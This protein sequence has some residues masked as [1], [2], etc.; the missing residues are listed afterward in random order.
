MALHLRNS[1]YDRYL[2][3]S[4][5]PPTY[6][7]QTLLN[8]AAAIHAHF[9]AN[10]PA[11][12][13]PPN[14]PAARNTLS[15]AVWTD[16][17]IRTLQI[18][19]QHARVYFELFALSVGPDRCSTSLSSTG[20]STVDDSWLDTAHIPSSYLLLLLHNQL[21][22]DVATTSHSNDDVN[23]SKTRYPQRNLKGRCALAGYWRNTSEEWLRLIHILK[24]G[25]TRKPDR[26]TAS[27]TSDFADV[28]NFLYTAV[29]YQDRE[30][31]ALFRDEFRSWVR[32]GCGDGGS[33][34]D[35]QGLKGGGVPVI[36][37]DL[38]VDVYGEED[39]TLHV[40][41]AWVNWM[42]RAR[43]L[44]FDKLQCTK[45]GVIHGIRHV[46]SVDFTEVDEINVLLANKHTRT[47]LIPPSSSSQLLHLHIH[48]CTTPTIH[49]LTPLSSLTISDCT[50]TTIT[51]SA[52]A[53]IIRLQ[54]CSGITLSAIC[55][56]VIIEECQDVK[57][58]I[59]TIA[60][61]IIGECAND[62]TSLVIMPTMVT[63]A[64][65]NVWYGGMEG[66]MRVAGIS[67]AINRWES[68][69][70]VDKG[71]VMEVLCDD[72]GKDAIDHGVVALPPEDFVLKRL[73]FTWENAS[74]S[75]SDDGSFSSDPTPFLHAVPTSTPQPPFTLPNPYAH[76]VS[77][78]ISLAH[79][80]REIISTAMEREETDMKDFQSK[81]EAA[82]QSWLKS[83]G[84]LGTVCALVDAGRDL[85]NLRED[86]GSGRQS[87]SRRNGIKRFQTS[88][89]SQGLSYASSC[90]SSGELE[91]T[92]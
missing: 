3:S 60:T 80:T 58:F 50:N 45:N 81:V 18:T 34:R 23:A 40:L 61:P 30:T 84:R 90:N 41:S 75:L 28:F 48:N 85:D 22:I 27:V 29:G 1:L 38:F 72:N 92:L 32:D 10:K 9:R 77:S 56:T 69:V 87:L 78:S 59:H 16:L 73:P 42:M 43:P 63:V 88:C 12:S 82:F 21:F 67:G 52:V 33:V 39:I 24:Y 36:P 66:D 71:K 51:V 7:P 68:I 83:T 49:I 44:V 64:P 19:K 57:L 15:Q 89:S 47:L 79:R 53:S 13:S 74:P 11:A 31:M 86:M 55:G 5:L 91:L 6:N 17:A 4:I 26:A 65:C 25:R 62:G 76:H 70:V 14:T 37:I 35:V 54:N 8:L 2:F 46:R 20:E